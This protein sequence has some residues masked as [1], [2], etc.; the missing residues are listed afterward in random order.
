MHYTQEATDRLKAEYGLADIILL[1]TEEE[2]RNVVRSGKG[3]STA[4]LAPCLPV[5]ISPMFSENS[6]INIIT[7]NNKYGVLTSEQE[8]IG[9][10]LEQA[11][12]QKLGVDIHHPSV[13]LKDYAGAEALA[14]HLRTVETKQRFGMPAKGFFLAGLPGTGKSFFAKCFAGEL[15]WT[16]VELNLSLFM[17]KEN[18]IFSLM[19]FFAFFKERPGKYVLW[20]DELEKMFVGDS[21]QSILGLLLQKINDLNTQS[22]DTSIIFIATANNI[23]KLAAKNPEFLRYGRFDYLVYLKPPTEESALSVYNLYVEKW[24]RTLAEVTLPTIYH[25]FQNGGV[26]P[27]GTRAAKIAADISSYLSLDKYA[28]SSLK[29]KQLATMKR[30]D[31]LRALKTPE[32]LVAVSI[33]QTVA[34][35]H[36]FEFPI[37]NAIM[38]AVKRY[39]KVPISGRFPYTPADIEYIIGDSFVSYYFEV[40]SPLNPAMMVEKYRPLQVSLEQAIRDMDGAAQDFIA[41]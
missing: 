19:M 11:L 33:F 22:E 31:F 28:T 18:P 34:S 13:T 2:I 29:L 12:K 30:G 14:G 15:G 24:N 6:F 5:H 38:E 9:I 32:Y 20:I 10:T 4:V 37:E 23:A 36:P 35:L 26:I 3:L 1:P 17:E 39:R 7:L 41:V 21:A 27:A 16:L 40:E 8:R 25:V